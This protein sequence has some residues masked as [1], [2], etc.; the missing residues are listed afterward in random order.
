M[1]FSKIIGNY[2]GYKVH[3][4]GFKVKSDEGRALF[5]RQTHCSSGFL[6]CQTVL[7]TKSEE[8]AMSLWKHEENSDK[9]GFNREP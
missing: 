7:H 3:G 9:I 4:S 6:I 5:F 8:H 2:S 1:S